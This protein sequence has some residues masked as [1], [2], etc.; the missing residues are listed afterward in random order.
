M[1]TPLGI[2]P[3]IYDA[4]FIFK[5]TLLS[6][7]RVYMA[8]HRT[9][10]R[11]D[12]RFV[13]LVDTARFLKLWRTSAF[14]DNGRHLAFQTPEEWQMDYKYPRAVSGFSSGICN[15]VPLAKV[16]SYT[17]PRRRF[18]SKLE[19]QVA[20]TDGLTRTIYL[21][22]NGA[23]SFP[24]EC[25][26]ACANHLFLRAGLQEWPPRS[27]SDLVP[28]EYSDPE[29]LGKN[30]FIDSSTYVVDKFKILSEAYQGEQWLI[31][32]IE[33]SMRK[34]PGYPKLPVSV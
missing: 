24:V 33:S 27:V 23:T 8:I 15:P 12:E 14:S 13:V 5:I 31:D 20:F 7:R 4:K 28:Y 16:A 32:D 25:R 17:L 29:F 11:N 1:V 18:F 3:S 10:Y 30:G 34:I 19:H 26:R 22:A 9:N 2:I 6:G 21:L